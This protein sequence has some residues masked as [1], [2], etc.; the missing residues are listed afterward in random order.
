VLKENL[1]QR[2]ERGRVDV[3]EYIN[4]WAGGDRIEANHRQE[5]VP[6]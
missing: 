3:L 1:R 2:F 6:K 5:C 4:W